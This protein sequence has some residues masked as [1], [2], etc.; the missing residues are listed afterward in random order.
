MSFGGIQFLVSAYSNR[1]TAVDRHE[2]FN[3]DWKI[4]NVST[5]QNHYALNFERSVRLRD[6]R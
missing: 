6:G 3:N 5:G 2:I 1:Y 4:S